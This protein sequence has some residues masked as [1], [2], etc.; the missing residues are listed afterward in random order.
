VAL[1]GC[2]T[3]WLYLAVTYGILLAW[4]VPPWTIVPLALATAA[5]LVSAVRRRT[6]MYVPMVLPLGIWIATVLSGWLREEPL[7]R[8]DDFFALQAPVQLVV[9]SPSLATC[10]P[11]E[12][13]PSGRF[14]RTIWQAPEGNR[15]VFTT[16]GVAVPDGLDGSVC[17]AH[18]GD[19]AKP[20]CVGPPV[21]KVQG[22]V[23]VPDHDRLIAI[24]WGLKSPT[25]TGAAVVLELPRSEGLTVLAEHW[26]DEMVAEGFYEPR[27]STLFMF[28]DHME[29]IYR[30]VLPSFAPAPML[31]IILFT[32]GELHYDPQT[33][34][35]IACGDRAGAAI[36]G[37]PFTL[38]RFVD[39]HSALPEQVSMTW[40][41]DWDQKTRKAYVAIPNLGLLDRID[42]DSG[43]VEKRWFVGFGMRSVAYDPARKRVY[44][45]N[46]LRGDVVAFDEAAERIVDRWFVG[47]YSRWVRLTRDGRALLATSNLGILR[48]PLDDPPS[49]AGGGAE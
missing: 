38:R 7:L 18:L 45:T 6:R 47:R 26:Y 36:R 39:R 16:Q 27:A 32:P 9:E 28:S 12:V 11:G 23:D 13:R 14:P 3:L 19:R 29:G 34:E 22:L 40:G 1:V 15:V 30:T 25:G 43:R 46:F 24:Q 21:S 42:Y 33:G 20:H 35:G 10:K 2:Y 5:W 49:S 48:I 31:P 37:E 4:T 8:C 41:C 17:E 44:F